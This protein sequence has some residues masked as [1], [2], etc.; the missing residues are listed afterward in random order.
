MDGGEE[1]IEYSVGP[2]GKI[3]VGESGV[4]GIV[5]EVYGQNLTS[6][7]ATGGTDANTA[8]EAE[9]KED[10]ERRLERSL[11]TSR[12]DRPA[13]PATNVEENDGGEVGEQNGVERPSRSSARRRSNRGRGDQGDS[14]DEDSN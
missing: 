8:R 4:A 5:R 13:P 1:V 11:A 2:R 7:A 6:S 14:M 3:E 12:K 9:Q 10:F